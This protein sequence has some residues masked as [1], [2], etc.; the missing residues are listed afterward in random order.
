M[1]KVRVTLKPVGQVNPGD[2]VI[3]I[4]DQPFKLEMIH[5]SC[6]TQIGDKDEG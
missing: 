1:L 2:Y 6:Q 5:S 4:K 3:W